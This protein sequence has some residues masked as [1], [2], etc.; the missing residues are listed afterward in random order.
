[1]NYLYSETPTTKL[2]LGHV[3]KVLKTLDSESVNCV[4][5]SP[6]YFGLRD[7]GTAKWEGGDAD[8]LH[9]IELDNE[10][11]LLNTSGKIDRVFRGPRDKCLKCDA[12]RVDEQLGLE[13]TF[14]EYVNNMVEV[15]E[16]IKRVLKKDGTVWLNLGDSYS[17]N[18]RKTT[19]TTSLRNPDNFK[20]VRPSIMENIKPKDLLGIPW[21]V[22]FALQENGWYLRQDIIWAKPNSMPE[23][24]KDR[25]TKSHEY[26]FL[27]AKS[28][29]YYYNADAIREPSKTH[30]IKKLESDIKLKK[31]REGNLSRKASYENEME[32]KSGINTGEYLESILKTAK[33]KG[34][35][36]RS[37][38]KIYDEVGELESSGKGI[39]G[40]MSKRGVT[41]LT[42]GLNLKTHEEKTGEFKNKRDVWVIQPKPYKEAHFAVFPEELPMNCIKAGCPPDGVVLDPFAGSGTTLK[43]AQKLNRKS[44]GIDINKKYLDLIVNRTQQQPLL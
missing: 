10:Q 2:Y 14:Y 32:A 4:V 15:F 16:E 18:Y 27:L 9:S 13:N 20:A 24:V 21:R 44:I 33:E 12:I 1:M 6:P 7:Y 39:K 28:E 31:Q 17:S 43:V 42:E 35:N 23:S 3:T 30:T 25:C 8:C 37:V 22:A 19:V 11:D 26:I 29:K 41:R 40:P 38:W 5:T 36:K 34:K